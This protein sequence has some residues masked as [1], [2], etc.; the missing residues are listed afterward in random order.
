MKEKSWFWFV[1]FASITTVKLRI[2][3]VYLVPRALKKIQ[4]HTKHQQYL[5]APT[6]TTR[7]WC[8]VCLFL[9]TNDDSSP[10]IVGRW[11]LSSLPWQF[12][13]GR[14]RIVLWR[15]SPPCHNSS[16]NNRL[17]VARPEPLALLLFRFPPR[18]LDHRWH[19]CCVLTTVDPSRTVAY[20]CWGWWH[21]RHKLSS[22]PCWGTWCWVRQEH[23]LPWRRAPAKIVGTNRLIYPRGHPRMPGLGPCGPVCMRVWV[24]R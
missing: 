1:L 14:P 2:S 5:P 23:E 11:W 9:P 3:Q 12:V 7:Q 19:H 4:T 17:D 16:S 21:R 20:R 13:M 18:P 24:G 15:P 6:T 22:C 8:R 10:A